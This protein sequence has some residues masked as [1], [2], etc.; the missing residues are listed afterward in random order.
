MEES[1][2][3]IKARVI[4][5]GKPILV[6]QDVIGGEYFIA[7]GTG[8]RFPIRELDFKT[9]IGISLNEDDKQLSVNVSNTISKREYWRKFRG[10]VYLHLIDKSDTLLLRFW[11][12]TRKT[13]YRYVTK[14]MFRILSLSYMLGGMAQHLITM[15]H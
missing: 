1:Y 6:R 5:S 3:W 13:L 7:K 4:V 15:S 12:G 2:N 11:F 14:S 9:P 8:A 10:D